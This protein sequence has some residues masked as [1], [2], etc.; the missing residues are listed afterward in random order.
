MSIDRLLTRARKLML[1]AATPSYRRALRH[2]VAAS[3][4]HHHDPIPPDIRTVIDVGA[5]RGQFA[6]VARERWPAARLVCFEPLS[7]PLAVLRRM[8]GDD[9]AVEIV[10][11]AVT[12]APG[13][14][15][16][17]VSRNDDSSSLLPITEYQATTFPGTEEV[18]TMQVPT[19][20]L[21]RHF[22]G[23]FDRP[24]LL[25]LDVQ[26][27]ELEVLRGAA[28]TLSAVD[29]VL[30]ECS[31]GEFYSGQAT[32]DEV[33]RFLHEH[34]FSLSAGTAPSIDRHGVILQVDL[35][36]TRTAPP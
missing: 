29:V 36:F 6:L 12:T 11:A 34:G 10:E 32:A 23:G 31:F 7:Q 17:H 18:A 25:K 3:T 28:S 24:A 20:S 35:I 2:G 26:G 22:H 8:L 1:I 14:A 9:H 19:T 33:I 21:D 4:E 15:T 30:V 5:N 27:F 13:M 16:I